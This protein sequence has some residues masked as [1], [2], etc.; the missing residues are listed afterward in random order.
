MNDRYSTSPSRILWGRRASN[1]L[2][3][4][5]PAD[6]TRIANRVFAAIDAPH[7]KRENASD[8][9]PVKEGRGLLIL[10]ASDRLGVLFRRLE[11]GQVEIVDVIT[12]DPA[13]TFSAFY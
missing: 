7:H 10:R 11:N 13:R 6:K 4:L 3:A 1:A 5:D 2:E 8:I 12:R 9:Q